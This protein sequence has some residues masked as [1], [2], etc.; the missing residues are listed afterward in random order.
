VRATSPD[1]ARQPKLAHGEKGGGKAEAESSAAEQ[2]VPVG[3]V[4]VP[5]PEQDCCDQ[6]ERDG[7]Q[8]PPP[9]CALK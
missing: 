1:Q 5:E 2:P 3:E 6:A 9:R 8:Q 4:R 7:E